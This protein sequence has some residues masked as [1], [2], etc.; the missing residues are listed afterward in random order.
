LRGTRIC[1][2]RSHSVRFEI[3]SSVSAVHDRGAEIVR[4]LDEFFAYER[5]LT[6]LAQGAALY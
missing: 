6:Q 1:R 2:S 3:D 4:E 5:L